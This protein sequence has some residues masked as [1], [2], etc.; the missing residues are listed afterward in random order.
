MTKKRLSACEHRIISF[1]KNVE[2]N[3]N[4]IEKSTFFQY[5]ELFMCLLNRLGCTIF[6]SISLWRKYVYALHFHFFKSM[7]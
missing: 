3:M 5:H 7:I 2:D 4:K 1:G 6:S